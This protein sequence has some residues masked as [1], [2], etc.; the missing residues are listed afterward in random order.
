MKTELANIVKYSTNV[1]IYIISGEEKINKF[2]MN[3]T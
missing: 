1:Y 3:H 2:G